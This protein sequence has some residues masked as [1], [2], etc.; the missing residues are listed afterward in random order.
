M[1]TTSPNKKTVFYGW[2]ENTPLQTVWLATSKKGIYCLEFNVTEKQFLNSV[3]RMGLVNLARNESR[4][5][6]ILRQVAAYLNGDLTIFNLEIDWNGVSEFT[7]L[8]REIVIDIPY[9]ETRTYGEIAKQIN[10]PGSSRAVGRANAT[11]PIPLIIPCHRVIASDGNLRG[12]GGSG[13][14]KT[15]RWL[16]DLERKHNPNKNLLF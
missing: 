7:Q 5:K 4:T 12:Y 3:N 11:N 9:G 8:C 1:K 6:E 15:K 2:I 14:I 16:L 13:G 10:K